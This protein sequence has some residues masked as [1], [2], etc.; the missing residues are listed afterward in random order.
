MNGPSNSDIL[1]P[2]F[3]STSSRLHLSELPSGGLISPNLLLL[4]KGYRQV[5][6][7]FIG[8]DPDIDNSEF[9]GVYIVARP[10]RWQRLGTATHV[11]PSI[12]LRDDDYTAPQDLLKRQPAQPFI[13]YHIG[14]TDYSPAHIYQ[15][16]QWVVKN[17]NETRS[18]VA[19]HQQFV[20]GLGARIIC[21]PRNSTVIMGDL[22]QLSEQIYHLETLSSGSSIPSGFA[23]GILLSGP[24]QPI[25]TAG[26]RFR[27]RIK[28]ESSARSLE[29]CWKDGTSGDID[30]AIPEYHPLLRPLAVTKQK[31]LLSL[32]GK[33]TPGFPAIS[34]LF[35]QLH[36]GDL[37]FASIPFYKNE[38]PHSDHLELIPFFANLYYIRSTKKLTRKEF[39]G[40]VNQFIA[41]STSNVTYNRGFETE[42]LREILKLGSVVGNIPSR[43]EVLRP[44]DDTLDNTEKV[45]D[46]RFFDTLSCNRAER[47]G[48]LSQVFINMETRT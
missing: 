39:L 48:L 47:E 21:G 19:S 28:I 4:A 38:K 7:H 6:D 27:L 32:I 18:S 31:S 35:P 37:P 5:H 25:D 41:S 42:V 29:F 17:M 11:G 34:T 44:D 2:V 26:K 13:A 8:S 23:T 22:L 10:N 30:W 33:M 9:F 16:A 3:G 12:T 15:I 43:P 1:A 40:H 20:W 46:C 36:D 14:T 24:T 45:D